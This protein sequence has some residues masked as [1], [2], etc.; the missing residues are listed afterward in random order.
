MNRIAIVLI[1]WLGWGAVHAAPV[2]VTDLRWSNDVSG[3]RLVVEL[4]G[5]PDFK[6]FS[7]DHPDRLV[8][9]LNQAR[10]AKPYRVLDVASGAIERIRSAPRG[11][12]DLR[13]VIDLRSGV[14]PKAIVLPPSA[15]KGYKLLVEMGDQPA[16]AARASVA[17]APAEAAGAASMVEKSPP[18]EKFRPPVP[19]TA[20]IKDLAP[21]APPRAGNMPSLRDVVVAIDAGHGGQDPGARGY[22]GAYEKD[23]VLA[24]GRRLEALVRSEPGM[25]PVMIRDGDYFLSLRERTIMARD[26]KADIFVSIHADA[27]KDPNAR[28]SSVFVVSE[29]GA[30]SEVAKWLADK[31]NSVDLL[32]GVKLNGKDQLLASVLLDLSQTATIQASMAAAEG[33]LDRLKRIGHVHKPRVEQAGFVVLKSPDIP[34]MLVETAFISNPAEE[35]KL[36]DPAHQDALAR[37][38]LDGVR[39]YFRK[40]PLPGTRFAMREHVIAQGET[41]SKVAERYGISLHTLKVS[42]GLAGDAIPA[43]AVLRIPRGNDG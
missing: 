23:V 34:S 15:S 20:S 17:P 37:A 9:D 16:D 29:R 6:M 28:G 5:A 11:R 38:I 31:E 27:F 36:L 13:L 3:T 26:L 4:T 32:G 41:L 8:V 7:L 22:S 43:G 2:T 35:K 25:R 18:A 24:I 10:M 14:K 21:S 42:N 1:A 33:V 30:S 40:Y 19:A 12:D 39:D